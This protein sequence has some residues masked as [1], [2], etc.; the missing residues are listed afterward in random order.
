MATASMVLGLVGII[1]FALL[2]IPSI[3]AVIFGFVGRNQIRR[4]NGQQ[5]GEGMATAGIVLGF[6]EIALFV[7]LLTLGEGQFYFRFG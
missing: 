3:L 4:S 1:A 2:A 7:A 6:L 5:T